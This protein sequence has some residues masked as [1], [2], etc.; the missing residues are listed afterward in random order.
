MYL[1][2]C[3]LQWISIYEIHFGSRGYSFEITCNFLSP[4]TLTLIS[5]YLLV[6]LLLQ[7]KKFRKHKRW[8]ELKTFHFRINQRFTLLGLSIHIQAHSSKPSFDISL[9]PIQHISTSLALLHW[10]VSPS[11]CILHII[12]LPGAFCTCDF[13]HCELAYGHFPK[14]GL[15]RP[16]QISSCCFTKIQ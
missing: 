9:H 6:I 11:W 12:H 4:P 15:N 10:R 14:G 1:F 8:W 13:I 7:K 16:S 5:S 2:M 3:V